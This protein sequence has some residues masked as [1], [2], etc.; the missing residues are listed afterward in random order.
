MSMQNLLLFANNSCLLILF[1]GHR[2]LEKSGVSGSHTDIEAVENPVS[3][4]WYPTI[5]FFDLKK[6]KVVWEIFGA[7]LFID[8]D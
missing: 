4:C 2:S 7:E 3:E 6:N 1:L 8:I 5:F